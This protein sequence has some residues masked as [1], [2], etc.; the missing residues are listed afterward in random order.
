MAPPRAVMTANALVYTRST[1][2]GQ[3]LHRIGA[4]HMTPPPYTP[5]WNGQT[6]ESSAPSRTNVPTPTPGPPANDERATG[7]RPFATTTDGAHTQASAT[8]HRSA[9][10]TTS[11]GRT[12]DMAV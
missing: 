10:F 5:R 3:L 9:A 2:F 11:V 1:R 7:H 6:K 8:G 4:R 12:P